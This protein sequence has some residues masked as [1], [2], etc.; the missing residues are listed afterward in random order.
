MVLSTLSGSSNQ[1]SEAG[2]NHHRVY[3]RLFV[4]FVNW[5]R[6]KEKQVPHLVGNMVC[7]NN[8][9]ASHLP[10]EVCAVS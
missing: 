2:G 7:T 8:R 4:L 10:S 6:S 5:L 3:H 9:Q 1:G